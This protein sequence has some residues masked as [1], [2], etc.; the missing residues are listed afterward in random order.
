MSIYNGYCDDEEDER[1]GEDLFM[2]GE[3]GKY[4]AYE[5]WPENASGPEYWLNKG[6]NRRRKED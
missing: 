5:G 2:Q 6:L 3:A 4:D 1:E